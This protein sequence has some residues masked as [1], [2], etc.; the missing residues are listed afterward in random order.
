MADRMDLPLRAFSATR[1]SALMSNVLA[2]LGGNRHG[3]SDFRTFSS[4]ENRRP[5]TLKVI[6][7]Y[8]G[9]GY[10]EVHRT[11]KVV[12]RGR[13]LGLREADP[14]GRSTFARPEA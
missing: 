12:L 13:L 1:E 5:S 2:K 6:N 3:G 11:W 7:R 8:K 14:S 4:M 10:G 9:P